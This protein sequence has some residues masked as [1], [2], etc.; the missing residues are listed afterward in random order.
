VNNVIESAIQKGIA[1]VNEDVLASS[2]MIKCK[3]S[4]DSYNVGRMEAIFLVETLK[5]K[6]KV[7]LLH[8]PPGADLFIERS[9]GTKDYLS[10]FP[11]IKIVAEHHLQHDVGLY[12]KIMDDSLQAFPDVSGVVAY[13]GSV[14]ALGIANAL[15]AAGK[16]PGEVVVVNVDLDGELPDLVREGWIT[17]TILCEPVGLARA[18]MRLVKDM[19]DGKPV[20]AHFYTKE[21]LITKNVVDVVDRSGDWV[22]DDWYQTVRQYLK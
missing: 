11:D 10:K 8:G 12:T 14:S 3:T 16:K 20:P 22:P 17:G 19:I 4:E 18:S 13:S 21:M 6:G 1:L 9:E 7:V 2:P 15:K 5:G